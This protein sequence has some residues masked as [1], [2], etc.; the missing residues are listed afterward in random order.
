MI[1]GKEILIGFVVPVVLTLAGLWAASFAWQRP[2]TGKCFSLVRCALVSGVPAVAYAVGFWGIYG[3]PGWVP[4]DTTH[5]LL[6]FAVIA[7]V[8]GMISGVAGW[9]GWSMTTTT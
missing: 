4:V 6:H 8:V 2:Q 3:W 7:G 1:T 9:L 5:W